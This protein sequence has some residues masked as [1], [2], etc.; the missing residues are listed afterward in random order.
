MINEVNK[1]VLVLLSCF[2]VVVFFFFRNIDRGFK[3]LKTSW[4]AVGMSLLLTS[5]LN[6]SPYVWFCVTA[7]MSFEC[8]SN[9]K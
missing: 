9:K 7:P 4:P 3:S 1:D 2:V 5:G 6:S 8:T